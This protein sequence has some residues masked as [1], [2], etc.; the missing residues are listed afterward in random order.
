MFQIWDAQPGEKFRFTHRFLKWNVAD[1]WQRPLYR[2]N[3]GNGQIYPVNY[4]YNSSACSKYAGCGQL[5]EATNFTSYDF[6]SMADYRSGTGI[7]GPGNLPIPADGNAKWAVK[8]FGGNNGALVTILV[9]GGKAA[10]HITFPISVSSCP[11][12]GCWPVP[13]SAF[14]ADTLPNPNISYWSDAR[15]WEGTQ[16]HPANP[17]N[18]LNVLQDLN[19]NYVS[20]ELSSHSWSAQLPGEGDDVWIPSWKHVSWWQDLGTK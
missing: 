16:A 12:A 13:Q 5:S 11:A 1:G 10:A 17:L 18:T 7:I 3:T 20:N 8:Q 14:P 4:I 6:D 2:L 9:Q 15:T 19:G